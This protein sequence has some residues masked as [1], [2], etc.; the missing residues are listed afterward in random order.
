MSPQI[1]PET[2]LT[3]ANS[4]TSLAD[5]SQKSQ[6]THG[7]RKRRQ[8]A[9]TLNAETQCQQPIRTTRPTYYTGG[10]Q[11]GYH[12]PCGSRNNGIK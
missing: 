10:A 8:L 6:R 7:S 3:V 9:A 2:R 12:Q 11:H 4:A 1:S 5:S